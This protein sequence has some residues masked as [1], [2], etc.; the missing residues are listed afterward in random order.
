MI[1]YR[2]IWDAEKGHP[3]LKEIDKNESWSFDFGENIGMLL[4]G[5]WFPAIR[6]GHPCYV[7]TFDFPIRLKFIQ[8]PLP[9][10][11]ADLNKI[12][13]AKGWNLEEWVKSAQELEN[14]GVKAIV[15]GC[16]MTGTMQK[17]LSQAVNIP[18]FTSTIQFIPQIYYSMKKDKK[19]GILT[20]SSKL[21]TRWDNLLFQMC[22]VDPSIP[23][24]I[25]GMTESEYGNIWWSQLEKDYDPEKVELSLFKVTEKM[26]NENPDIGAIIYE[27][28][29][30]PL[31]TGLIREKMGIP[32]FDANDMIEFVYQLVSNSK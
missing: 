12:K 28:T 11:E 5:Q 22:E 18:V 13:K 14:E 30:M 7:G 6:Y 17:D 8:N 15:T 4:F 9:P 25:E 32:I 29:E 1:K 3:I 10:Q 26:L 23:V 19:I 16:G 21:L 20:A 2:Q 24:I 31:Y 27:C